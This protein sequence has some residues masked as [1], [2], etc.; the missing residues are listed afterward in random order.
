MNAEVLLEFNGL[1]NI[2]W[3]L[4]KSLVLSKFT[5]FSVTRAL[6]NASVGG[7]FEGVTITVMSFSSYSGGVPLSVTRTVMIFVLKVLGGVQVKTPLLEPM[8]A[9]AG[10]LPCRLKVNT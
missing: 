2:T 6:P 4:P 9:P 1:R 3:S 7:V 5:T 10:G 8:L